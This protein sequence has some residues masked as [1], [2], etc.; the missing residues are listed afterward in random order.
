MSSPM[1]SSLRSLEPGEKNHIMNFWSIKQSSDKTQL[2]STDNKILHLIDWFFLRNAANQS[3]NRSTKRNQVVIKKEQTAANLLAK[4]HFSTTKIRM[5]ILPAPRISQI[6]I[7]CNPGT[8]FTAKVLPFNRSSFTNRS[9][10]I[11]KFF[12][13][14]SVQILS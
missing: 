10:S 3:I 11:I 12:C 9:W 13:S 14:I 1:A 6:Q 2:E 8:D 7:F 5:S 4:S